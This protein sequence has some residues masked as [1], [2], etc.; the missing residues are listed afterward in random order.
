MDYDTATALHFDYIGTLLYHTNSGHCTTNLS[1]LCTYS[2]PCV[3]HKGAPFS[4][5]DIITG[6][7][8]DD[9]DQKTI[10]ITCTY[11]TH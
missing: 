7:N 6:R 1:W 9:L 10:F 2:H 5:A 8:R 4:Q 11:V 3:T